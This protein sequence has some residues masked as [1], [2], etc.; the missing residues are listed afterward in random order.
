MHIAARPEPRKNDR[1]T[2]LWRPQGYLSK[3]ADVYAFGIVL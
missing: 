1:I 3:A 2:P